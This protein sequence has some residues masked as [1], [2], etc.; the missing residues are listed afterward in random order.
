[1]AGLSEAEHEAY[2]RAKMAEQDARGALVKAEETGRVKE[3]RRSLADLC[4][5][6]GIEMTEE[7]RKVLTTTDLARLERL[8]DRLKQE[9]RWPGQL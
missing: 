5:L 1:M 2:E 8:R 3:L 7:H 9:R 4:E 6:L